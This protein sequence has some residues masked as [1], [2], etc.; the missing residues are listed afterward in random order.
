MYQVPVCRPDLMG[1]E[2]CH[3]SPPHVRTMIMSGEW[4]ESLSE[5]RCPTT[6][7][8][9]AFPGLPRPCLN[10]VNESH[11]SYKPCSTCHGQRPRLEAETRPVAGTVGTVMDGM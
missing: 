8:R 11:R 9:L 2:E 10:E 3:M 5:R 4:R 7:K 1:D 6:I